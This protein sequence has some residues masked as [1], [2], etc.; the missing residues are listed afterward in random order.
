MIFGISFFSVKEAKSF[1]MCFGPCV[2]CPY[3]FCFFFAFHCVIF[4]R[5]LLQFLFHVSVYVIYACYLFLCFIYVK[6]VAFTANCVCKGA[7]LNF[8]GC[9]QLLVIGQGRFV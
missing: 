5:L 2:E 8:E 7:T 9:S 1:D 3:V 6:Y 4:Y